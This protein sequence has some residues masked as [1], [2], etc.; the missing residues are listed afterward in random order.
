MEPAPHEITQLLQD[1]RNGDPLA[2]DRLMWLIYDDLRRIARRYLARQAPGH[3]LQPTDLVNEAY[4]R[5]L[6]Q[7]QVEWQSRADFFAFAATVMRHLLVDHA[8]R[9][10]QRAKVSLSN[11]EIAAP[12]RE[13]D[14]L[15]LD[16]ALNRLAALDPQKGRIIE[17]RFFAG[18]TVEE[19]AAVLGIGSATV[20]REWSRARAWLLRELRPMQGKLRHAL[21][22]RLSN[23]RMAA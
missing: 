11:V 23:L 16:E 21:Y 18:L 5:L 9:K 12:E 20:K 10:R 13:V 8:R 2:F 1:W 4:T 6:G 17:L 3:T 22:R 15:A 14:L 19:T 7:S